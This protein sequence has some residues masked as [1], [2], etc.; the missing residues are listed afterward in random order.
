IFFAVK[1]GMQILASM[2]DFVAALP[3]L[4]S[5]NRILG[6]LLGFLEVY[7][8]IFIVLFILALTPVAS[9]QSWIDSSNV[10][11]FIIEKTPYLSEKIH[12][13]WITHLESLFNF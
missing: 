10:A 2:L 11:L 6:A 3:I 13:L 12:S 9:I 4:N 5:I 8:L 7:L 1:I